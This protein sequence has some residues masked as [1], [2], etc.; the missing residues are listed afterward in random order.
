MYKHIIIRQSFIILVFCTVAL[1][2][3]PSSLGAEKKKIGILFGNAGTPDE[4]RADWTVQFFNF[5]F[6]IF[7]PGFLA[8]GPLEGNTCYT[9]LSMFSVIHTRG[10]I[11]FIH[12]SLIGL[13]QTAMT[14][15]SKTALARQCLLCIR[16]PLGIARLI[17]KP[18]RKYMDLI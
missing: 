9:L 3:V 7:N 13:L 10:H 14:V 2:F 11:Q 12:S 15:F 8:G 17:Q 4:Y 16:S 1:S 6:D 18:G 5:M